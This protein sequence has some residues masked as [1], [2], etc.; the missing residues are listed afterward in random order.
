MWNY[1]FLHDIL[2]DFVTFCEVLASRSV[3]GK[4]GAGAT[5]QDKSLLLQAVAS[6]GTG[7]AAMIPIR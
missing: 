1:L 3:L 6:I 2:K 5:E 4:Y 7:A